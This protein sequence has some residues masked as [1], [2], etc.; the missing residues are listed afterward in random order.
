MLFMPGEDGLEWDIVDRSHQVVC[1]CVLD[2]AK[3]SISRAIITSFRC[4]KGC[5]KEKGLY[6]FVF[7]L[8]R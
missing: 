3:I 7:L 1:I 8:T 6:L 5:H 2:F 4:L